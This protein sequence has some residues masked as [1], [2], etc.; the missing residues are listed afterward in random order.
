MVSSSALVILSNNIS[1]LLSILHPLLIQI[2]HPRREADS[3]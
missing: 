1:S 2:G 3:E